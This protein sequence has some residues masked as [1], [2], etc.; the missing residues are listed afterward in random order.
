VP[1]RRQANALRCVRPKSE[2][3]RRKMEGTGGQSRRKFYSEML[4]VRRCSQ[5]CLAYTQAHNA[6]QMKTRRKNELVQRLIAQQEAKGQRGSGYAVLS[7][8]KR[9][10]WRRQRRFQRQRPWQRKNSLHCCERGLCNTLQFQQMKSRHVTAT[11]PNNGNVCRT[12]P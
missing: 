1:K 6:A 4:R 10:L 2:R 5:A 9:T 3:K 7:V 11:E 12:V 8:S